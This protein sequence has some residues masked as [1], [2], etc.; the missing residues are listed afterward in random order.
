MAPAAAELPTSFQRPP[1]PS[2]ALLSLEEQFH[3][4]Q[5]QVQLTKD[6]QRL[7]LE[8]QTL[9]ANPPRTMA[10]T[11]LPLSKI[12]P[13]SG[14]PGGQPTMMFP[15]TETAC[16]P[17]T[18]ALRVTHPLLFPVTEVAQAGAS[19][20]NLHN[21]GETTRPTQGS[22]SPQ[23]G[24]IKSIRERG[25]QRRRTRHG[26]QSPSQE[27]ERD[28]I[29]A[30]TTTRGNKKR[31][32][33]RLQRRD[34]ETDNS[35]EENDSDSHSS[36]TDTDQ[37]AL[38]LRANRAH[39]PFPVSALKELKKAVSQYGPTAAF[40]LAVLDSLT[41]GWI[42][43]NDWR[44]LARATLSGGNYLLWKVEFQ[45][46]CELLAKDNTNNKPKCDMRQVFLLRSPWQQ[47]EHGKG[48]PLVELLLP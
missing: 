15:V 40:T 13:I 17:N 47:A 28:K 2:S 39:A 22:A 23:E 7:S 3:D 8:L 27:H 19:D 44:D 32:P 29:Q 35:E 31:Q 11:G 46:Q 12:A 26:T 14:S 20:D 42:T 9:H 36:D 33:P 38:A 34:I 45:D 41:Q 24:D 30:T 18:E 37:S 6:I 10:V 48:S 4:L 21:G 1:G 16:P 43:P 5:Q 25:R